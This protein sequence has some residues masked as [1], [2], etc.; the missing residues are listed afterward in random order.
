MPGGS[1]STRTTS[2][3]PSIDSTSSMITLKRRFTVVPTGSGC[4]VLMKTPVREMFV[5]YSWMN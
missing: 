3:S 2:P 5:T 4:F 1:V